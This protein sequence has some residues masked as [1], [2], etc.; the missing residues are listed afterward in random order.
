MQS[1]KIIIEF[2][3]KEE[4]QKRKEYK[5]ETWFALSN[6]VME[7]PDYCDL[8]PLEFKALIYLYC[9]CSKSKW[10]PAT[11]SYRHAEKLHDIKRDELDRVLAILL[12][13]QKVIV[14]EPNRAAIG[15]PSGSDQAATDRIDRENKQTEETEEVA[16]TPVKNDFKIIDELQGYEPLDEVLSSISTNLQKQWLSK[17]KNAEWVKET[18]SHAVDWHLAKANGEQVTGWPQKLISWLARDKNRPTN[19]MTADPYSFLNDDEV[20]A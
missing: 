19:G 18:L 2:K 12:A 13:N 4:H 10:K 5:H 14:H 7:N 1:E 6:S 9:Q 20:S 11:I 3:Q 15:Q 17:Y 16:P 8:S